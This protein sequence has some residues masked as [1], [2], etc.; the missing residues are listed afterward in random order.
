MI[1][2][3]SDWRLRFLDGVRGIAILQ[4]LLSGFLREFFPNALPHLTGTADSAGTIVLAVLTDGAAGLS[5]FFLTSGY[6]LTFNA[7]ERPQRGGAFVGRLLRLGIPAIAAIGVSLIVATIIHL[8]QQSGT[9]GANFAAA[10]LLASRIPPPPSI[11]TDLLGIVIGYNGASQAADLFTWATGRPI[12]LSAS[13]NPAL[14]CCCLQLAG[15][16]L[17]LSLIA[18]RRMSKITWAFL[19]LAG[20][21]ATIATPISAMLLGHALARSPLA[22]APRMHIVFAVM[23]IGFGFSLCLY[24]SPELIR[25]AELIADAFRHLGL[26]ATADTREAST[27]AGAALIFCGIVLSP[28][29]HALLPKLGLAAIGLVALPLY[30][31]H[32]PAIVLARAFAEGTDR[33]GVTTHAITLITA[34]LLLVAAS[35]VFSQIDRFALAASR[36]VRADVAAMPPPN[37][38]FG[39]SWWA[40]AR[41]R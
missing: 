37:R 10:G 31:M 14:W 24:P 9:G 41:R 40:G 3:G 28:G 38:R 7:R 36:F 39:S 34:L 35:A 30:L 17:V 11:A 19:L 16:L 27:I 25:L 18:F 33:T 21:A 4:I 15:S 8:P 32:V 20:L 12:A 29:L 26:P 2:T 13:L 6:V 22:R 1:P 5:L 23:L